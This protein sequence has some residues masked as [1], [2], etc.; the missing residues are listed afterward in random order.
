MYNYTIQQPRMPDL[1]EAYMR[2]L[3]IRNDRQDRAMRQRAFEIEEADH[4]RRIEQEALMN[5]LQMQ[6]VK[7][8]IEKAHNENSN[9]ALQKKADEQTL[10]KNALALESEYG[11]PMTKRFLQLPEVERLDQF[12]NYLQS[13]KDAGLPV[14]PMWIDQGYTPDVGKQLD[15]MSAIQSGISG[16]DKMPMSVQETIWFNAQ[17]KEIQDKHI[18][19]KRSQ[20]QMNL[21]GQ[22]AF[23]DPMGGGIT[24]SYNVTPKPQDMP[25][26][27]EL[28]SAASERGKLETQIELAP[29]LEQAKSNISKIQGASKVVNVVNTLRDKYN[30][31]RDL[32]GIVDLEKSSIDNIIA[33]GSQSEIGQS[34][35]KIIGSEAQSIRNEIANLRT[36]GL[37]A[38]KDAA[39]LGT[40]SMNTAKEMEVFLTLA[41]DP[42]GDF[43]SN[44]ENLKMFEEMYGK[45][46][47]TPPGTY[48]QVQKNKQSEKVDPRELIP[49]FGLERPTG[50]KTSPKKGDPL[51]LGL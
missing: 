30:K 10:S 33:S 17:P 45:V 14:N 43:Q 40:T 51:G 19:L 12:G 7:A 1:A 48:R 26:F 5:P 3:Q 36:W 2:G 9:F 42:K 38:I 22:I 8:E 46:L 49:S 11:V 24:E 39:N 23:R 32:G 44:I 47:Q 28:Q 29:Q 6:L 37:L 4:K 34:F 25:F 13:R 21:G 15:M 31:L 41:T 20:Q 50:K 16:S 18:A 27:K 35:Q